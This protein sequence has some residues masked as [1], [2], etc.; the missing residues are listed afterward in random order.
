[1][2]TLTKNFRKTWLILLINFL[3]FYSFSFAKDC[4]FQLRINEIM[5]DPAGED[6]GK[7]WVEIFNC[8]DQ[9]VNL[10]GGSSKSSWNFIDNNGIH[11]LAEK[12]LVGLMTIKPG[13][14]LI[15]ASNAELF[16]KS[17][18]GFSGSVID[19]AMSL[20]NSYGFIQL[21]NN[22]GQIVSQAF[23]SNNLGAAGNNKTLEYAK[24]I[25]RE[26]LRESGSPG[27]ENSVE[28]IILPPAP[29]VIIFPTPSKSAPIPAAKPAAMAKTGKVV[30]S[31]VFANPGKNSKQWL[32]IKNEDSK[33]IDLSQWK[34]LVASN[35]QEVYLKE[36]V[37]PG[38]YLLI[39]G[40]SLNRNN[41]TILLFNPEGKKMFEVKYSSLIPIDW[42]AS[43]FNQGAWK[44]T[45]RPTPGKENIYFIP[46]TVTQ[47]FVPQ[48]LIPAIIFESDNY[49][50]KD[51]ASKTDKSISLS[52]LF[53]C[54]LVTSLG[55]C[56]FFLC[57]K[58]KLII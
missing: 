8:G 53:V 42:S 26:G 30:I 6:A 48:E 54:G 34:V 11:F 24:G 10:L 56:L 47:D 37:K 23:W 3:L 39:E 55:S 12:P 35:N 32:E 7:E 40:I 57:L 33:E 46:K 38:D 19:T 50:E 36:A 20:E 43:R 15:L 14:Y 22:Q 13:E 18:P 49:P 41:E 44:I 27:Q 5:Y 28:N 2:N 45:A 52:S 1:M 4:S 29:S 21:K 25:F 58:R 51:L 16:L 17:H 31:E 9:E